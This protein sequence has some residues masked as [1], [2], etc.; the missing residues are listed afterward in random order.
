[1][2]L[3]RRLAVITLVFMSA[4][5]AVMMAGGPTSAAPSQNCTAT[6]VP[7][8]AAVGDTITD[9]F[10]GFAPAETVTFISTKDGVPGS[11]FTR[12]AD[13]SGSYTEVHV[14]GVSSVGV[15]SVHAQG[16]TS[17]VTCTLNFTLVDSIPTTT[18][19]GASTTTTAPTSTTVQNT[20]TSVAALPATAVAAS[21][22]FT[23]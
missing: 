11:P 20:T 19:T 21:A 12:I 10:S 8:P 4:T 3:A 16:M 15:Y 14:V 6:A 18:T 9:T 7:D 22:K 1:M 2:A 17:G 5:M 23:G 13:G